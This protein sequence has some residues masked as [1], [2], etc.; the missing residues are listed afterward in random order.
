LDSATPFQASVGSLNPALMAPL[1]KRIMQLHFQGGRD[2]NIPR[3]LSPDLRSISH[4]LILRFTLNLI[5]IVVG[6]ING[7]KY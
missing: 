3:L 2:H 5:I 1:D 4:M 6:R 7:Q